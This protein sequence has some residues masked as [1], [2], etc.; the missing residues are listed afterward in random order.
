VLGLTVK[1][2]MLI[3]DDVVTLYYLK[4][5]DKIENLH[6]IQNIFYKKYAGTGTQHV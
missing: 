2:V 6:Y 3:T 5:K 1:N 4:G